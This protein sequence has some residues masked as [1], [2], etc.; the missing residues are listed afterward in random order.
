MKKLLVLVFAIALCLGVLCVGASAD[1]QPT[2]PTEGDGTAAAPYKIGTAAELYWFAQTVNEGDYDANAELTNDITINEDVLDENGNLI[3]GKTFT[4]WT[5]I[6]GKKIRDYDYTEYTGTFD[7]DGH[8]ISG[9]YYSGG[10]NYAGLFGFV[11]SNGRVQNVK[12]A[13]SYISNS[14]ETGRTGGVCG[15]NRGTIMNCSFSGIVT[16]NNSY[17]Y[18]GG[19]CGLNAGTTENCYNA[20]SVTSVGFSTF[21]GGVCGYNFNG[22]TIRNCYNT[23]A[24]NGENTGYGEFYAGGV[25]GNNASFRHQSTITNCYNTGS[26]TVN[27]TGSGN[28]NIYAGG[29][30]GNSASLDL[31]STITNCYNT[32][33]V[34]VNVTGSGNGNIYAGGVCGNNASVR[35][36]STITNCYN[37]GSVTVSVTVSGNGN[38]YAGGVCGFNSETITNCYWR[39]DTGLNGCGIDIGTVTNV[40]SKTAEE[41]AS[42]EVAWLLNS[43]QENGPWRQTLDE[44]DY[45][46]LDITHEEVVK[47]TVDGTVSYLNKG[48]KFEGKDGKVYYDNKGKRVEVPCEVTADTTLTSKT[49]VTVTADSFDCFVG[50]DKPTLTYTT[51]PVVEGLNVTLECDANMY[52]VGEYAITISGPETDDSYAFDYVNEVLKVR[53]SCV[54]T[55]DGEVHYVHPGESFTLPDAPSKAGYI[56]L[57]WRS[58]DTTYRAEEEVDITSNMSFTAVWGNLPDIDPEEPE[59]EPELPFYDVA[60]GDWFYDAVYYVW[61]KGLMDGVEEHIFAPNDTLTRAMVWTIIARAEGVDTDGGATWCAKAQEWVVAKGIS[62][63]ENPSAAITRQELVTMLWRLSGEPVVNYALTAPDAD[64][65]SGWAYEAMRWAVSEGIIEGDDLGNL[66]PTAN[67]TRAHAAAFMQRF[68]TAL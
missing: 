55:V 20:G 22:S 59:A 24:V 48:D 19:V 65:I 66:N 1:I 17:T 13:D 52:A 11:G 34:T 53:D 38:I 18:V 6:C 12:V 64:A 37:T 21:L 4:Q 2:K 27:V 57:G 47:L 8:T 31:Q 25:C 26:V 30:C 33:S 51:S 63:G 41:F 3:T 36:Q 45:P 46:V 16:C 61:E 56:F 28:G 40:K 29:V 14:G 15:Y 5:P 60:K 23:G 9:L 58:G 39:E 43:Y 35:H 7:G 54:V 10:G 50:D 68:C 44:D 42:G 67:S 49:L 62:D 32:G